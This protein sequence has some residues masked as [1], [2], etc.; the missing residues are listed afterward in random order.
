MKRWRAV[1]FLGVVACAGLAW[2][3]SACGGDDASTA[4][5][6]GSEAAKPDA[7]G[8]DAAADA[9]ATLDCKSYCGSIGAACTGDNQQYLDEPTCEKMC[10]ILPVGTAADKSG[11]TLGCRVY[12]AGAASAGAMAAATHCDHAGPYG[13]GVCGD[14]CANFCALY[15][16]ECGMT[17]YGSACASKC[18]SFMTLDAGLLQTTAGNNLNCREYHLENAFAFDAGGG[19]CDHAGAMPMAACL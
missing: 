3:A 8:Q 19:H 1:G 13:G 11:N 7:G 5:D 10:A 4:K 9:V 6:A 18:A 14:V 12:H 17:S 2:V 15:E 16:A